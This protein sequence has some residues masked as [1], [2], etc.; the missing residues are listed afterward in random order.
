MLKWWPRGVDGASAGLVGCVLVGGQ[1]DIPR[2]RQMELDDGSFTEEELVYQ[3]DQ[4]RRIYYTK[5]DDLHVRSYL[6]SSFV[7]EMSP[8]R[9][10][11]HVNSTFDALPPL[12]ALSAAAR[13]RAVY[14]SMFDGYESYFAARGNNGAVR[15]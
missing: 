1:N 15:P 3:N 8:T 10:S 13:F 6:A 11:I 14:D 5:I 2:R 12:S 9:C 4:L 7:D